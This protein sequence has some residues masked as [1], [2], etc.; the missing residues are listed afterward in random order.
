MNCDGCGAAL[1]VAGNRRHFLCA[2]CGRFEF[3]DETNEGISP[4]GQASSA[5]CPV[6][7]VRLQKALLEGEE[8]RYCTTCRGFLASLDAFGRVLTARRALHRPNDQFLTPFDPDDLKRALRCPYCRKRMEAHP[9]GGGGNAA[10]DTCHPCQLIWLDA[11]ELTIIE[12]YVPGMRHVD[13]VLPLSAGEQSDAALLMTS[14]LPV[15][16]F[17]DLF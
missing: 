12:S 14:A 4:L 11:G 17:D 10:V 2:Y 15:L 3:P 13:P 16:G 7:H 9:F 8:V 1:R 5:S 6:C